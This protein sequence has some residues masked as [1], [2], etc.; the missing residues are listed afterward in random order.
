MGQLT[1]SPILA[2]LARLERRLRV[3][4]ARLDRRE[5]D[6]LAAARREVAA[7]ALKKYREGRDR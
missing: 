2:R 3:L 6:E 1:E 4:E 5:R 7:E